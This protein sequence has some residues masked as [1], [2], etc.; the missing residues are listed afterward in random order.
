M[1]QRPVA[2]VWDNFGPLHVDRC[3]AAARQIGP[4]TPVI[5]IEIFAGS[6]DYDWQQPE[7]RGF[8][9]QTLFA[10]GNWKSRSA[11]K[12]SAAIVDAVTNANCKAA[13]LSHYDQPAM[14]LAAI[15]LRRTG[16][17]IFTMGCSKY[18]DAKRHLARE[19]LKQ[20]FYRPYDGGIGSD[21]RSTAYMRR[22]GLPAD[23]VLGGYNTVNQDRIRALAARAAPD[24]KDFGQR[25]FLVVARLIWEKNFPG[26]L[27]A[28]AQYCRS[29][30]TPRRLQIAG[31][32]PL[33]DELRALARELD[34]DRYVD[35]L[36]FVQTE[37]IAP[38]MRD[39]LCLILPSVSETFGN[40]V[41]E[42][43]AVD[44]PIVISSQCGAADRLVEDGVNGYSFKPDDLA[45]LAELLSE[46]G[47][48]EARWLTLKTGSRKLAP[49]GDT[50][51][52]AQSVE[53]LLA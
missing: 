53:A 26:L 49:L 1:T 32:G 16:V 50:K 10:D 21:Y 29:I 4:Q 17:Q 9:K 37:Q 12:V 11:A 18:D 43:L 44:L 2:F 23:R 34:I 38:L 45:R 40:V 33:D 27:K 3:E 28:Y 25:P 15:R 22:L 13:F 46:I 14:L 30:D 42:A 36:G 24:N 41:P 8:R 47:A 7:A 19:W 20:F 52:F 31:S 39:A 6:D 48:D 5:G 35:W 51:L